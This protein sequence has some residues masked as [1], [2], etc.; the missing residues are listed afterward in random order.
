MENKDNDENEFQNAKDLAI[1]RA[2]RKVCSTYDMKSYLLKKKVNPEFIPPIILRLVE[3]GLL[4]DES[5][6]K[7]LTRTQASQGK[8][9]FVIRQK[10]KNHGLTLSPEQVTELV[11]RETEKPILDTAKDFLRRRYP[12]VTQF[13]Q[14]GRTAEEKKETSRAI[15][16]LI[17]RGFSYA[18]ALEALE[19]VLH[20]QESE[21]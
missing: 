9:P 15:Q 7:A 10:L 6:T 18:L 3:L 2:S 19:Q 21:E 11:V 20:E 4:N 12:K 5:F 14:Y 13:L 1:K 16:S 8:G 17:R